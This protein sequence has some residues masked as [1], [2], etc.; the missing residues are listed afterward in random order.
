PGGES[1]TTFYKPAPLPA[2]E[3]ALSTPTA[4]RFLAWARFPHAEVSPTA[5]GWQIRLRDLRFAAG[6]RPRVT[7]IWMELN[8][9]LELRAEGAGEPR[10]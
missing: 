6:A 4:E 2:L 1:F 8:P 3:A 7:A 5:N 10:R 9:E